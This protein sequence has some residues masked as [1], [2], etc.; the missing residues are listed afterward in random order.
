VLDGAALSFTASGYVTV[1]ATQGGDAG[2]LPAP[3]V[4]RRFAVLTE[5]GILD[6]LGNGVCDR[7]EQAHWPECPPPATVLKRGCTVPL[8]DVFVADLDPFDEDIVLEITHYGLFREDGAWHF[9][10]DFSPASMHR[11][12]DLESASQVNGAWQRVIGDINPDGPVLRLQIPAGD[13]SQRFFRVR[14]RL[15]PPME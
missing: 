14:V 1:R 11:L 15:P 2:F 5:E 8:R 10:L 3:P 13:A 6:A 12:Y 4:D 7:W 9:V